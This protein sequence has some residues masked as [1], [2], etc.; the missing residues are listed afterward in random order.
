[1]FVRCGREGRGGEGRGGEDACEMGMG[2]GGACEREGW[3]YIT[4]GKGGKRGEDREWRGVP[5]QRYLIGC[6]RFEYLAQ[7][8]PIEL[9][10]KG[11][12]NASP[13]PLGSPKCIYVPRRGVGDDMDRQTNTL[14]SPLLAMTTVGSVY[15]PQRER[16]ISA[17]L[18]NAPR[19]KD[20]AAPKA[21]S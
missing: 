16:L 4:F 21:R 19:S 2:W 13:Q 15:S 7:P 1:M 12:D 9:L 11:Y 14:Q 8:H 10:K 5:E 3:V 20:D 17:N 6:C 18:P